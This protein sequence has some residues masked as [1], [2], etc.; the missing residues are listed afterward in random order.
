M[1]LRD[2]IYDSVVGGKRSKLFR[3][4]KRSFEVSRNCYLRTGF[5]NPNSLIER[6]EL[7]ILETIAGHG[8]L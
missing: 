2:I 7:L 6:L 1:F 3:R 8:V 4:I 5:T